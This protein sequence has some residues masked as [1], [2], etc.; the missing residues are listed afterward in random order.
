VSIY[1]Y[2]PETGEQRPSRAFGN[3]DGTRR[4]MV[5]T[6]QPAADL[7]AEKGQTWTAQQLTADFE[8]TGFAA[9]FVIVRRR[10]DGAVGS[11]EFTHN[12]RIYFGW[13]EDAWGPS[14]ARLDR[15]EAKR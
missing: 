7:A 8:V 15:R 9:P 11:L 14:S 1:D 10:S 13:K 5:A 2:D 6:G 12:P 3:P 4:A